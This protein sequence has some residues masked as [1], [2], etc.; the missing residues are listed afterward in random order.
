MELLIWAEAGETSKQVFA[1]WWH[2]DD[3]SLER[4]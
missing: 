3:V 2:S 4:S 1:H